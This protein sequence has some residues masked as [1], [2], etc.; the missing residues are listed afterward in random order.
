VKNTFIE[1]S[2]DSA[3]ADPVC[4]FPRAN[5][6]Q[7]H[8]RR[9]VS[10]TAS[11]MPEFGSIPEDLAEDASYEDHGRDRIDSEE[12]KTLRTISRPHFANFGAYSQPESSLVPGVTSS[13]FRFSEL[14]AF[15]DSAIEA[16]S[17][18]Q[19]S[20]A[21]GDYVWHEEAGRMGKLSSHGKAFT[22]VEFDGRLSMVTE[23]QVHSSGIHRYVMQVQE[24][25]VSV[26]D[27]IGFVFSE[28]LPCKK[29]I[30]KIDSIFLNRKGKI[31][32]RVRNEV[33]MMNSSG[34]GSIDVGSVVEL[35][36]DLD[37][38][39]AIFSIYSPP[40]GIDDET[41]AI[42]VR[43]EATF[44]TWLTGTAAISIE[45]VLSK[46]DAKPIGHFCAVLKN[47]RTKIRFL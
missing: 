10:S 40:R 11:I 26:A 17:R 37:G 2:D 8:S 32:S 34:I 22:K 41:M 38:L 23:S 13:P 33:E 16:N 39:I 47:A 36:V 19:N 14:H 15:T 45:P 44:S 42:L 30:Q 18:L 12:L 24:G 28:S 31:C 25:P 3:K 43:D 4:D 7:S 35:I 29:N 21:I 1:V 27:G 5:S 46:C 6:D 9:F 20:V